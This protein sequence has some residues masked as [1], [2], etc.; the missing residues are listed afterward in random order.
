VHLRGGFRKE[1]VGSFISSIDET[2]YTNEMAKM[3]TSEKF[4]QKTPPA[5]GGTLAQATGPSRQNPGP[6]TKL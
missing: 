4:Y 1:N 3:T 6:C 5:N 2:T